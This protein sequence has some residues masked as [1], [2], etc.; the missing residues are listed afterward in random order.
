MSSQ[1]SF[2]KH[3]DQIQIPPSPSP[4]SDFLKIEGKREGGKKRRREKEKEEKR[5]ERKRSGF[6][7]PSLSIPN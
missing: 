4:F 6:S 3:D 1:R 7:P 5:G 2:S